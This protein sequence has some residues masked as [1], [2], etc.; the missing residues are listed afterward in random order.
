MLRIR[1]RSF[2]G[3]LQIV[4]CRGRVLQDADFRWSE[5]ALLQS[6]GGEANQG[7]RVG[8]DVTESLSGGGELTCPDYFVSC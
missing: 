1:R 4:T 2:V 3:A 8:A 6:C 5:S 7:R